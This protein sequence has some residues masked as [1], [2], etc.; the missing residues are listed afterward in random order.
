MR[1]TT[2]LLFVCLALVAACGGETTAT[3]SDSSTSLPTTTVPT[4]TDAASTTIAPEPDDRWVTE[5]TTTPT[6]EAE[7]APFPW[8]Y[9]GTV[10]REQNYTA[11]FGAERSVTGVNED[12]FEVTLFADGS[13]GGVY[14]KGGNGSVFECSDQDLAGEI[15]PA[16]AEAEAFSL[17]SWIHGDGEIV[18]PDGATIGT[19]DA[20]AMDLSSMSYTSTLGPLESCLNGTFTL[21]EAYV[22]ATI[23]RVS[24]P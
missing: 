22:D 1:S 13:V 11:T 17:D 2:G 4:V 5:S 8:T 18:R 12:H 7:A 14:T 10:R 15:Y 23:P 24:P 20:D 21:E 9:E 3:T 16:T 6:A 19:Y